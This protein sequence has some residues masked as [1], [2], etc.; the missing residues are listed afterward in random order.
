MPAYISAALYECARDEAPVNAELAYNW[1][2]HSG[3]INT[4]SI[5]LSC[6]NEF[7]NLFMARYTEA[8]GNGFMINQPKKKS[9]LKKD[10]YSP[11]SSELDEV[12]LNVPRDYG[13]VSGQ[14]PF[15]A[16]LETLGDRCAEELLPYSRWSAVA[17]KKADKNAGLLKLPPVLWPDT[18][19]E[20]FIRLKTK[21]ETG[22]FIIKAGEL[23]DMFFK[24]LPISETF[25]F[26]LAN[27]LETERIAFEP[28]I[29]SFQIRVAAKST[30]IL[31][32]L[33]QNAV[34]DRRIDSSYIRARNIIELEYAVYGLCGFVQNGTE[35][36]VKLSD[37]LKER[38]SEYS[39]YLTRFPPPLRRCISRF[40][41]D[42]AESKKSVIEYIQN[43]IFDGHAPS[44]A[45][46]AALEKIYKGFGFPEN[47]L[48]KLLHEGTD[49]T[50]ETPAPI[51]LDKE[52]IKQL[53]KDSEQVA[54]LLSGIFQDEEG[55]V[56]QKPAPQKPDTQNLF[57]QKQDT[58]DASVQNTKNRLNIDTAHSDFLNI[59]IERT[60]WQ[61]NEL[62]EM[63]KQNGFM[64]DGA[65]EM[66][67]EAAYVEFDEPLIE[68]EETI[69]IN[70]EIAKMMLE[71]L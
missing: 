30:S 34:P 6:E 17:N 22:P 50:S 52:K 25:F 70:M 5:T 56:P 64:L 16:K 1:Y 58:Q 35:F 20:A 39:Y 29:L 46:V 11:V 47:D 66:I 49:A 62:N 24:T 36:P 9:P 8:Y 45:A 4:R 32:H 10:Y 38:I 60:E 41:L 18:E 7:K 57:P 44:Y 55:P 23:K 37:Y 63:A 48:H 14:T 68:G 28:D 31:V 71:K 2:I 59:I 12:E 19:R 26:D 51:E 61:R 27:S 40:S 67:N 21:L 53:Q 54:T 42:N 65:I 3:G 33:L 13:D 69:I 15:V 43:N